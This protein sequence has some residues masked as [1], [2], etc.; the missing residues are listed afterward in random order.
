MIIANPII[1]FQFL[2][3]YLFEDFLAESKEIDQVAGLVG[4]LLVQDGVDG[5]GGLASLSVTDDQLTL[6]TTDRHL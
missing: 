4:R 2:V 3:F 1:I 5:D 6:A